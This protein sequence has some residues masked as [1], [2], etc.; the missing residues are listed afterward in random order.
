MEQLAERLMSWASI[1]EDQ[2]REQAVRTATL[3]F[4]RPYVAL[5]PDAHLGKGATVGSVIPTI[6]AIVPAAVGVDI[7]C[8]MIALRTQF[9]AADALARGELSLLRKAIEQAIPLSAGKH[10]SS[11]SRDDTRARIRELEQLDGVDSAEQIAPNWRLQLGSLGSGNHFI[12]VCVDEADRIWLFLH[13]GS[14]GVGNKLASRHIK[15]ARQR[16]ESARIQLP[17]QDLAYL[18][19]DTDEFWAYL[20]DLRWAQHFA[21]LNKEDIK[22]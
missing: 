13:S 3:P 16:C 19:E 18:V 5:M 11:V 12:E 14:R 8:G 17:D 1:L 10:N 6:D 9:T 22:H 4:I 15:V 2:T 20:V 21:L 7:G